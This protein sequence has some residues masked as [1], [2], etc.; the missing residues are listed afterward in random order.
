VSASG[1]CGSANSSFCS[2]PRVALGATGPAPGYEDRSET[3]IDT[4]L[5]YAPGDPV[6]IRVVYREQRISVTDDGAAIEKA[7][8]PTGWREVAARLADEL[9]V[10][11]SR[12]GVVELPV[13]RVGP[14]EEKIVQRI[15]GASLVL[16]QELLELES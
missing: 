8:R 16:Y 12:H 4:G 9:V 14:S 3:V 7:G 11:V 10:N 6:R 15:G 13:V 2:R 5:E 1:R